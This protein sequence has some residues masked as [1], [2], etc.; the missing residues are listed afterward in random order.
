MTKA[1]ERSIDRIYSMV[2]TLVMQKAMMKRSA[3]QQA[4]TASSSSLW[5]A[6]DDDKFFDALCLQLADAAV[7]VHEI[8]P[9]TSADR[10]NH[11]TYDDELAADSS[12]T[13]MADYELTNA[14][15]DDLLETDGEDLLAVEFDFDFGF[16]ATTEHPATDSTCQ[17]HASDSMVTETTVTN[18][19]VC[20]FFD[21][22]N[23]GWGIQEQQQEID[24][25]ANIAARVLPAEIQSQPSDFSEMDTAMVEDDA[26]EKSHTIANTFQHLAIR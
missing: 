13:P 19:K 4:L 1:T 15:C 21:L 9:I 6:A 3:H 24:K 25:T 26:Q 23:W 11:S 22:L 5:T 7:P 8:R 17:E 2:H 10:P 18:D 20:A 16:D 14:Y 12:E